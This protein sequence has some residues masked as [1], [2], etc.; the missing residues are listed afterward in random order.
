MLPASGCCAKH[1][2][3]ERVQIGEE[4]TTVEIGK[5]EDLAS[6]VGLNCFRKKVNHEEACQG[7]VVGFVVEFE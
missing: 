6:C 2:R 1:R 7:G 4:S 3:V 5:R